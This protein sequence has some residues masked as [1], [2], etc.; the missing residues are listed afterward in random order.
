MHCF[1]TIEIQK[2]LASK[3][4]IATVLPP[5]NRGA[6]RLRQI[7]PTWNRGMKFRHTS[8]CVSPDDAAIA[9]AP[10]TSWC[11]V[12]GTT[13]FF[14]VLP[15]VCSTR[16]TRSVSCPAWNLGDLVL[17]GDGG[18]LLAPSRSRKSQSQSSSN[19]LPTVSVRYGSPVRVN[20]PPTFASG[21]SASGVM[22]KSRQ[23][24]RISGAL[25]EPSW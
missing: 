24:F 5:A 17:A 15:L 6:S 21:V 14:P 18:T 22:F 4:G 8:V 19:G 9:V 3:K 12:I 11:T 13:F 23:S 16:A 1:S 10:S 20:P 7:P 2:S 25:S